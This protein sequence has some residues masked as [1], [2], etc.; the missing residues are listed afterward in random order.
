[1]E[2]AAGVNAFVVG[3][4]RSEVSETP[5][6]VSPSKASRLSVLRFVVGV[7]ITKNDDGVRIYKTGCERTVTEADAEKMHMANY[8]HNGNA[9]IGSSLQVSITAYC[10]TVKARDTLTVGAWAK[11]ASDGAECAMWLPSQDLCLKF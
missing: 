11:T 2:M 9:Q 10:S 5:V 3:V 7:G 6:W 8:L 1:M 4:P